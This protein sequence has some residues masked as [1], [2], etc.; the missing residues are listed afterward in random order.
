MKITNA[1]S[2]TVFLINGKTIKPK[3]TTN[4][5][6]TEGTDLY[7]QIMSLNKSGILDLN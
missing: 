1:S 7:T 5:T 3:E 4:I 6:L 2:K